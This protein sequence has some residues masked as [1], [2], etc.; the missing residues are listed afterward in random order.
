[1]T[2]RSLYSL[3][4]FLLF[5]SGLPL[6][7]G[8]ASLTPE[9]VSA[10]RSFVSQNKEA[11]KCL[12]PFKNMADRSLRQAPHPIQTIASEGKLRS[13]SQKEESLAALKDMKDLQA[14]AW[15]WAATGEPQY[16]KKAEEY[17]AAWAS[18]NQSEG[19]PIND[20]NLE[21]AV[22][23]YDLLKDNL[24]RENRHAIEGWL[25]QTA[26]ALWDGKGKRDN[27]WHSQR[28]KMVGLI[29]LALGDPKLI[30]M[31]ADGLTLQ[32][33]E[34]IFPDGSTIDFHQRDA[35]H[36][37]IYDIT[38]LLILARGLE[39]F[40]GQDFFDAK[41]STGSSL[42]GS[43]DFV[44]PFAEG[45]ETHVEF[46]NSTVSF[47]KKRADNGEA[48]YK[49]HNWEPHES[50]KMFSLA[51]WFHPQY[52]RY[53]AEVAKAPIGEFVNWQI[54]LNM[55]SSPATHKQNAPL[56]KAASRAKS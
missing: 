40:D 55:I 10:L 22:I 31:A 11:A 26:A 46:V 24:G 28:L 50:E 37:H 29:G 45:K 21:P 1:M 49:P 39:R 43:V 15:T 18:V 5:I 2:R 9:E 17:L 16:A 23:A 47:D 42:R 38:P 13:D 27:N 14:L 54:V 25:R 33:Q 56:G 8:P 6:F 3:A 41:S 20:T 51:A 53:A 36:Y 12:A 34:N 32:V 48:T 30:Q 52:G 44:I 7:G 35:L 19:N 4:T